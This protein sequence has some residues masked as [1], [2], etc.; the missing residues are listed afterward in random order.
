MKN[1]KI[2]VK[3]D[4]QSFMP[5]ESLSGKVSWELDAKPRKASLRLFWF[6]SG[7]GTEDAE[8]AGIMN[9]EDPSVSDS[10][11]FEFKM[12]PGPY[13]FS[14][15]L[16]SLHWALELEAGGELLQKEFVLS[17]FGHEILLYR[18]HEQ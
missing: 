10:R 13:S 9:F 5:G 18:G 3:D 16:I 14:G 4:R 15:Q 17:P 2:D 1:L 11:S 12:P 6:T 7:K 8:I